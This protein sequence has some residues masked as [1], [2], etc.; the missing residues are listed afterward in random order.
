MSNTFLK[1]YNTNTQLCPVACDGYNDESYALLFISSDIVKY[2]AF[3][4]HA[5][6]AKDSSKYVIYCF[7]FQHDFVKD[8]AEY[9]T[10]KVC[11]F[12]KYVRLCEKILEE[13]ED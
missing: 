12:E 3:I 9:C 2:R 10:V 6:I 11:N 8:T 4:E 13:S 5:K 1:E 7:P